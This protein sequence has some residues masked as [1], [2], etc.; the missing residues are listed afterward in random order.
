MLSARCGRGGRGLDPWARVALCR[1]THEETRRS[2]ARAVDTHL[3]TRHWLFV[4]YIVE[5]EQRG[6]DRSELYG[7]K[8]IER[9]SGKLGSSG[10]KG[11]SPANLRKLRELYRAY[12][13]I[14]QTLS[15]ESAAKPPAE[16]RQT[17]SVISASPAS[18]RH[19]TAIGQTP[20]G[21]F[22]SPEPARRRPRSARR[23]QQ[24]RNT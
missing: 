16:I 19:A 9:L 15:V 24:W 10:L 18:G 8:L 2:A 23:K 12:P 1:W 17:P 20:P 11:C 7:K 3:M 22:V 6:G 14:Q 13:E 21:Q 4:R 5:Y